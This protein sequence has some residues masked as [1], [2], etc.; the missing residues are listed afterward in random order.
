MYTFRHENGVLKNLVDTCELQ[1]TL[2]QHYLI[3]YKSQKGLSLN[4]EPIEQS[5]GI[6]EACLWFQISQI[7]MALSQ[8]AFT[9]L[10]GCWENLLRPPGGPT[11]LRNFWKA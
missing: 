6:A 3:L 9:P 5:A 7:S 11:V 8:G 4:G 10:G 1:E 2:A